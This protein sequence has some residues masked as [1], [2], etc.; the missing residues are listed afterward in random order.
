MFKWAMFF[1]MPVICFAEYNPRLKF[2]D[3]SNLDAFGRLRVSLPVTEFDSKQISD[4][5]PLLWDESLESGSGITSSYM[6]NQASSVFLSTLNTAGKYTRQ[7]FSR[8]N[9]RPGKSQHVVMT[10]TLD[11]SGGGAGV[12][13]RIG[14]FDDDNGLFFELSNTVAYVY[15]RSNVTGTPVDISVPQSSWNMD[16][17]DGSGS[18]GVTLD[19]SNS[20]IFSID[21]E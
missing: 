19:F 2:S 15:Q 11:E 6:T 10:G 3:S 1:L 8:F 16:V 7:T 4:E 12:Q 18:S 14:Q 20:Q 13:R 9:Y 21:Y 17:M 5:N